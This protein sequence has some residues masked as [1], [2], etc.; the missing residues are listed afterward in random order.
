[1]PGDV[2]PYAH[3][4]DPCQRFT[5]PNKGG[6]Q[7]ED[8]CEGCPFVEPGGEGRVVEFASD[9]HWALT[10][11]VGRASHDEPAVAVSLACEM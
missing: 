2:R 8:P 11:L 10:K 6:N 3:G 1:M 4:H 5:P 7:Q 9:I